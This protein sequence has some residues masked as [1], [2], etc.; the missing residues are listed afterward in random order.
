MAYVGITFAGDDQQTLSE[1]GAILDDLGDRELANLLQDCSLDWWTEPNHELGVALGEM[2]KLWCPEHYAVL[3]VPT[4][5]YEAACAEYDALHHAVAYALGAYEYAPLAGFT[6]R[7]G[8]EPEEDE[9]APPAGPTTE[10]GTPLLERDGYE[11]TPIEAKFY[12]ELRETG[13]TFSVQ[14]TLHSAGEKKRPDFLIYTNEGT[15]A[16][17]VDGHQH[18]HTRDQRTADAQRERWLKARGFDFWR[19][20]GTEVTADAQQCVRDLREYIERG[21]S[22]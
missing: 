19:F 20:T 14:T 1:A 6:I 8:D 4:E 10:D 17:E 13:L 22:A 21:P 5:L 15:V 12:D 2:Y 3:T 16:V 9:P 7:E 11:L 18:H